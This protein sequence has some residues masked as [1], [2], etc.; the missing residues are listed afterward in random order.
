MHTA[1]PRSLGP[2]VRAA[3]CRCMLAGGGR[4]WGPCSHLVRK[5]MMMR[6]MAESPISFSRSLRRGGNAGARAR[7]S[8]PA[9]CKA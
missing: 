8:Q 1:A 2:A 3:A 4:C 9:A 5:K 7:G 6:E